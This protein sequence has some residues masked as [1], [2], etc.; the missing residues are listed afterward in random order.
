MR[1]QLPLTIEILGLKD[2]EAVVVERAIGA[3]V[4]LEEAKRIGQHLLSIA[5][6][7]TPPTGY[8]ILSHSHD[9]VYE[10][11]LD[12]QSNQHHAR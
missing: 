6:V 10:V 3:T 4:Y 12:E 9:L 2:G 5:D 1:A 8:R 7:E 11:G